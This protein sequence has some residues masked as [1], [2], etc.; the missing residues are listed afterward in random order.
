MRIAIQTLGTR[1]DVQPYIALAIGLV[2]RGHDVQI[3]APVQFESLVGAHAIPF[4]GLPGEFL[5]LMDTEEGKAAI[6]GGQGF[7]AGLKL[8][9]YMRP[10]MD[11]LLEAET[12]AV[13]SFGPDL[14]LHHPKS[15][16]APHLATALGVPGI[17]A[18]PLPGFTPTS[19]FP[20]PL[21]PFNSLGPLNKVSHLLATRGGELLFAKELRAWRHRT[22]GLRARPNNPVG[23][24]YAYSPEVIPVPNDWGDD[25]LVSGYWFLDGEDWA[26]DAALAEFLASG[27]KP[28]YVGFGSVPGIDPEAMTALVAEALARTGKRGLLATGGGALGGQALPAHMHR[29]AAAPHDRLLPLVA[30]AI[31]HGG[32]GTTGAALR[33]GLPTTIVPFFGDQ[34]FWGR[35][36]EQLGVGPRPLDRKSLSADALADAIRAM[37]APEMRRRAGELGAAIRQENG[38]EAA[39]RFIEARAGAA[40]QP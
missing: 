38:I 28:I 40:K 6:G 7:S 22:L 4:I 30:A 2:R 3:A 15:L 27:D 34:P 37:D 23:T 31:H 12:A 11:Q 10:L 26:P 5:A 17:L 24:L 1:G 18:S 39:I 35:R 19:A 33:A 13:R 9:K 20:S 14:I 21:L 25:V 29:I 8:L 36:I 32:A 16:A